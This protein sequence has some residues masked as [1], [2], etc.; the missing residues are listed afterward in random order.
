MNFLV[1]YFF[2]LLTLT[3]I[4][5]VYCQSFINNTD[6]STLKVERLTNAQIRNI[7]SEMD[8]SNTS[9]ETLENIASAKGMKSTDFELLKNRI[10]NE[11]PELNTEDGSK[12]T[13]IPIQMDTEN[14]PVKLNNLIFGSDIFTNPSL[15]FEPNSNMATPL[16]Y[17]LGTG[18]ELQIVIYGVQEFGTSSYVSKDGK[19]SI[20]NVGQINVSGL[21]IEAATSQ[22]KN[23]CSKVFT[24]IKNGQSNISI[25]LSKIRTI[26]VTIIGAQKSGNYS[27]S[28]LSTVFN[29]LYAAGGPNENGSYRNIEVI[30]NNKLIKIVD[31]YKFLMTGTQNENIGLKDNDIIRIPVYTCRVSIEGKV[32]KSGIFELLPEE[33]FNDLLRYCSGFN[34]SAYLSTIKLVQNTDKELRIIDLSKNEYETYKPKSGD[35]FKVSEILNR[36][37]NRISIKGSVYRPDDYSFI[38]GMR[39]QDLIKKADGL[40][41]DAF[42]YQAQITRLKEDYSK[43]IISIN[44]SKALE[45]DTT[46]NIKLKKE[47]ELIIFSLFDFKD[48]LSV[49]I[50]G[51]I[52]KGG[53][54]PFVENLTLFDVIIQA[55][56]FTNAASKKI[57]IS[58]PVKKDEVKKDQQEIAE[59]IHL[60]INDLNTDLAKNIKLSPNDIILIRKMPI[61]E[62]QKSIFVAGFLEFPGYY[63]ISNKEER[64]LDIINRAG[65]LKTEANLN[66][67]FIKRGDYIIPIKFAKILKRTNSYQNIKVQPGD[68]LR[69][70]KY[71]PAIKI[72]GSVAINT[73][74][75]FV[76]GKGL[77][78]YVHQAGGFYHK[79][80]KKKVYATYPN[81]INVRTK[82]FLGL[83]KYP[84][85]LAGTT[86]NIPEKPV[87]EKRSLAEIAGLAG[88]T[89]SMATM[90]IVLVNSFK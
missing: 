20:P 17:I 44:L 73:E 75:P 65:G 25:T 81:G 51:E 33:N 78:Y 11:A 6:F 45:N 48:Q 57:E 18:D 13:N 76:K 27:L 80:W 8:R 90:I 50:E 59:I 7:K 69:V 4:P 52:R 84:P 82:S 36:F 16:N 87:K 89:S 43:E 35:V 53:T 54:Y 42:K 64:V 15:T 68:E 66:G 70:L 60:E 72:N 62:T 3:I 77:K 37:E 29:A 55:G 46:H 61:Y 10:Q 79:G 88:I 38:E 30:R 32:K 39:I 40:K 26:K 31:I 5:Q 67:I 2:I 34:E 21:T 71:V 41:E 14:S 63:T 23:A 49:Q 47:D 9:F 56:G 28:S 83:R 22:I 86:I 19:I 12:I 85:I 58:R 74:I 24:T 1:K